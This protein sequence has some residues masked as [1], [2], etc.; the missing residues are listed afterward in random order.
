V[1]G[2]MMLV[3]SVILVAVGIASRIVK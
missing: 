3:C 1:L 2:V